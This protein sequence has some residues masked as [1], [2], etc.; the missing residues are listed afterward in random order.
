MLVV[1]AFP[2]LAEGFPGS[3]DFVGELLEVV[4]Y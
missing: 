4:V 1:A 2:D 3:K